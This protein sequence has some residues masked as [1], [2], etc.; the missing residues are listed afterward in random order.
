MNMSIVA[1][2]V[3]ETYSVAAIVELATLAISTVLMMV[4]VVVPTVVAMATLAFTF[5]LHFGDHLTVVGI[6]VVVGDL[7][8]TRKTATADNQFAL[9]V[10][11]DDFQIDFADVERFLRLFS[12]GNVR[13]W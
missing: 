10:G 4:V 7:I 8:L 1:L 5:A 12:G 6:V 9:L 13:G 3:L 2:L 11:E